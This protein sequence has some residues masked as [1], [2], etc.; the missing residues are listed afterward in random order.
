MSSGGGRRKNAKQNARL[1]G[2]LQMHARIALDAASIAANDVFNMGP[3]R[4]MAF[5][6]AYE[7]AYNEIL[8][9][10][11]DDDAV[12]AF[13]VLDRRL[14]QIAGENFVPWEKRYPEIF[15]RRVRK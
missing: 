14:E 7:K 13:T 2:Q 11:V 5:R 8:D 12:Y 3:S 6:D 10:I 15:R 1:D 4:A 9:M